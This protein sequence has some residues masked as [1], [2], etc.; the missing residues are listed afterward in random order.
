MIAPTTQTKVK[1]LVIGTGPVSP[2]PILAYSRP[3]HA[4]LLTLHPDLI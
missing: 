4:L 2:L 3:P 1:V